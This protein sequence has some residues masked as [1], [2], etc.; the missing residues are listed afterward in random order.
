MISEVEMTKTEKTQMLSLTSYGQGGEGS[1]GTEWVPHHNGVLVTV[2]LHH[3]MDG[4]AGAAILILHLIPPSVSDY[5]L[6]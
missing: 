6:L 3:V 5:L 1:M 2:L 4:E